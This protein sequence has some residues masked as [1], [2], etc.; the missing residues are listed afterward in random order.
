M[1]LVELIGRWLGKVEIALAGVEEEFRK[2]ED[3]LASG[4]AMRARAAAHRVLAKAPES[5]LGLA[6]LA[7]ACALAGLDAELALTLE[8]LARQAPSRGEV[9]LRLGRARKATGACTDEVRD[10]FLRA[11]A[12]AEPRSE[13]HC[14]ALVELADLDLAS[15]DGARAELWLERTADV[16]SP[17]VLVRRAE[18]RLL[19][20]DPETASRLL[21]TLRPDPTDGRAALARGR[22]LA[23][24]GD[25]AAFAPLLRA[26]VLDVPDASAMLASTLA[27]VRSDEAMRARVRAIVEAKGEESYARWRAAFA[28]AQGER[29]LARQALC[30]AVLAGD[31]EARGPLLEAALEDRDF[32][33]LAVVLDA[34]RGERSA[35]LDDA[36]RLPF[37]SDVADNARF[38]ALAA[39]TE[40][41][42]L[43]WATEL[44]Q[45]AA[46]TWVG[47]APAAWDSLLTRLDLH[48][49]KLADLEAIARLAS[50]S[51]E[52]ARPVRI[53]V[54]GEFNAGKSTFINALIGAEVAPTGVLP[55]TA[56][57]H[58][59]RYAPDPIARILFSSPH[60]PPERLV[61][62]TELRATLKALDV[63]RVE[64]VE[65][66]LP[67]TSLTRAEILDT[68]GFNAPDPRHGQAARAAFD[69]ADFA[70]W[71][72]D[73]SQP[74]KHSERVVLEEA[75]RAKLPVQMLVNKADRLST[76]DLGRVM[77]LVRTSLEGAQLSSFRP[78]LAL[79]ARRALAGRLGDTKALEESGWEAVQHLLDTEIV[80]RS[81]EL[82]ERAL[83]RRASP[84]VAVLLGRAGQLVDQEAREEKARLEHVHALGQTASR[85]E[86]DAERLAEGLARSLAPHVE[87]WRR[88]VALVGGRRDGIEAGQLLLRYRVDR[89]LTLLVPPLVEGLRGL[90]P[91]GDDPSSLARAVVRTAALMMEPLDGSWVPAAR[92]A[93]ATL[94]ERL[95]VLAAAKGPPAPS[96]GLLCELGAFAEALAAS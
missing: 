39:V 66:L 30:D 24:K 76:D 19:Q 72:L 92:A 47:E 61:A 28:R 2:A 56:T 63:T 60:E 27:W 3:S 95:F 41:R 13:T 62:V 83:R 80:A 44:V 20:R 50:L 84:V 73:A 18:A 14:E 52:R 42:A 8:D 53:A 77:D 45:Q 17:Q 89:A 26:Y 32:P 51:A 33:S 40:P 86:A 79:S 58:H 49:R 91:E 68:P 6:L 93:L 87:A 67:I 46:R 11:V 65:I 94:A 71:L 88:D 74:I 82:K 38:E 81:A 70:V 7:D 31:R 5:P 16:R 35:L 57:L 21:E 29:E 54:V 22:A 55:T 9:W 12:L 96:R 37:A 48:A 4:D 10:A 64:R 1:R 78:P 69:E 23:A 90:A 25:P 15:Y 59:L 85:L 75:A 36:R 34:C 43:P